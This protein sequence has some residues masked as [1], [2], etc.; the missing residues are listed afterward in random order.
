MAK[1]IKLKEKV[2]KTVVRLVDVNRNGEKLLHVYV[3]A[4]GKKPRYYRYKEQVPIDWY[5]QKYEETMGIKPKPRVKRTFYQEQKLAKMPSI[6]TSIKGGITKNYEP[7]INTMTNH[8]IHEYN[9]KLLRKLVKDNEILEMIAKE[10]N[11]R[12]L[13]HRQEH[14]ITLRNEHGETLGTATRYNRTTRE[15][16]QELLNSDLIGQQIR[17]ITADYQSGINHKLRNIGYTKTEMKKT[18]TIRTISIET[19]FIKGK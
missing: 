17:N 12:K 10:E 15:T 18:G 1:K 3:K 6:S 5:K 8:K 2:T 7:N 19:N 9:K 11:M 14:T 4:T 13:S 16:I